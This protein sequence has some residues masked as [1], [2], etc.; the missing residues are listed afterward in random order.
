LL[1]SFRPGDSS[2]DLPA[3]SVIPL[4][5]TRR[6][7]INIKYADDDATHPSPSVSSA[8]ITAINP[9]NRP[10]RQRP[11]SRVARK[12]CIPLSP[13]F[14]FPRSRNVRLNDRTVA[15]FRKWIAQTFRG[16]SRCEGGCANR[17][18]HERSASTGRTRVPP[19]CL[20]FPSDPPRI[21]SDY[22]IRL[23]RCQRR[24]VRDCRSGAELRDL[25]LLSYALTRSRFSRA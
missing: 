24:F 10:N 2:I 8:N 14:D 1:L 9:Q 16:L 18:R 21:H 4:S 17:E 20:T 22:F 13:A 25:A 12:K 7:E 19:T 3:K 5:A 6:C 11:L 23:A 15:S